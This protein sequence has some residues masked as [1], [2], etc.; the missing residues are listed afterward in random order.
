MTATIDTGIDSD[1][2]VETPVDD[3]MERLE[4]EQ[5]H[6]EEK[7]TAFRQFQ[8][9][10]EELPID[11]SAGRASTPHATDGGMVAATTAAERDRGSTRCKQVRSAFAETVASR[12]REEYEEADSALAVLREELSD[13]LALVLAPTDGQ[14]TAPVKRTVLSAVG[15][16]REEL[17]TLST[18]LETEAE[19]VRTAA[20]TIDGV[21]D[22]LVAANE[23][24][25]SELGFDALQQ[26]HETLAEHRQQC[27]TAVTERQTVLE[28]TTSQNGSVGVAHRSVV[29]MLYDGFPDEHPVLATL[30]R[31]D[32]CCAQCQR[33]MRDHLVRRV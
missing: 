26:R 18:A 33:V 3:A 19:S 13:E 6:V 4:R 9:A 24:P 22:W 23:T 1:T 25:L 29:T 14:F 11:R 27:E 32:E 5:A 2:T 21:T 8:A 12:C 10:V 15:N 30:A 7:R 16:R 20:D 31:L 28:S 17:G